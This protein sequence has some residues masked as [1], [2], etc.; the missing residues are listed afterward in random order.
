MHLLAQADIVGEVCADLA[1]LC[2]RIV[3]GAGLAILSEEAV[4][5]GDLRPLADVLATQ[6]AWSDFPFILLTQRGGGL[7][8]NPAAGR[9]AEILGNVTF[10]ERPFHPT[11]LLSAARTAIR[12][13]RRQYEARARMVELDNERQALADLSA[14][15]EQR[16]D[17]R[18]AELLTEVAAREKAQAQLFQSQKVESLGQLTGGVAHDFNN[19]LMAVMGNL[20]L[21]RKRIPRDERTERLVESAL[22]GARRGAALTQRM[23]SFARQQELKT[24]AVDLEQML[25]G[26][27][28]LIEGAITPAINVVFDVAEALP[29]ARADI[30]QLEV[31][32]LNLCIN[33]RDAMPDGGTITIAVRRDK[34]PELKPADTLRLS[35]TDTGIGMDDKT[36]KKAIE[37]FFSTKPKGKGTGL[38]LSSVH[39]LAA[40][41]GG[42]F[43]IRSRAGQGTTV[44]L[45]IPEAEPV[46]PA[47]AAGREVS[48]AASRPEKSATI[49]VVDDDTLIA[50]STVDMLEDLGHTVIEANSARAALEIIETGRPLDLLMTDHV[51][52]GMTGLELAEIVRSKR[53]TLPILLATGYAEIPEGSAMQLPRLP[54]PYQQSQL[55]EQITRLLAKER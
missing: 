3:G 44:T 9:L 41:L 36:L 50:M 7:E 30:N 39:G 26:I 1:D 14:T 45:W 21:L 47:S 42:K 52:P 49:L 35:V 13:R 53:P 31:A 46:E 19:L 54:K 22:Q 18:T 25:A 15:L 11:T 4:V 2:T 24:T 48:D 23:L 28:S 55:D 38:G 37:P 6:P 5:N 12:G 29:P 10:L 51:M 40:Q 27:R 16:V 34:V 17:E 43:D 33:A 20:D 8:R 32:V